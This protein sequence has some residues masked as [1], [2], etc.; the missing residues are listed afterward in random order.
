M[1]HAQARTLSLRYGR[2]SELHIDPE[3]GRVWV[4]IDTTADGKWSPVVVREVQPPAVTLEG[5]AAILCF[6]PT[7]KP[8]T[9]GDCDAPPSSITVRTMT[10]EQI[11]VFNAQGNLLAL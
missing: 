5:E 3:S 2:V 6:G 8:T 1:A 7:G 11:L 9:E 10:G 4:E